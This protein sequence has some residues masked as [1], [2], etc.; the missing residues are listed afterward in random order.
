MPKCSHCQ[1]K[2]HPVDLVLDAVGDPVCKE[3]DEFGVSLILT[4][5][6]FMM[7]GRWGAALFDSFYNWDQVR[8]S[9]GK[10][11][12][13]ATGTVLKLIRGGKAE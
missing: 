10:E 6:G 12:K 3:C 4:K 2:V 9:A 11:I 8:K 13:Q 7:K 1:T 5:K